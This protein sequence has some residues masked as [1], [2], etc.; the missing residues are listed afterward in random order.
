MPSFSKRD[1]FMK[2]SEI[3]VSNLD[4]KSLNIIN[5]NN[6][7]NINNNNFNNNNK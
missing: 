1:S 3:Y 7:I 4:N 6:N 5:N 2:G